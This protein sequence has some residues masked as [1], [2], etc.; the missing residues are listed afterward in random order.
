MKKK[1]L[2]VVLTIV[3]VSNI[4]CASLVGESLFTGEDEGRILISADAE[5]MKAFGDFANG[6][7]T[8][9]KASPDVKGSYWQNRDTAIKIKAL[10]FQSKKGGK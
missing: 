1:K 2:L 7:V 6:L 8:E 9:G 4:G 5:G 10:K 3:A